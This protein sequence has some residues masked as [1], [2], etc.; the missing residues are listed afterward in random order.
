MRFEECYVGMKVVINQKADGFWTLRYRG[1]LATIED[2][3]P[4]DNRVDIYC[5][6]KRIKGRSEFHDGDDGLIKG[7]RPSFIDRAVSCDSIE[8]DVDEILI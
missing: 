7:V 4:H 2:I 1:S 3:D 5:E 6:D 8:C